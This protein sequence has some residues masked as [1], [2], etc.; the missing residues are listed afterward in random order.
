MD[1]EKL[2]IE[3]SLEGLGQFGLL[4]VSEQITVV[5]VLQML[6]EE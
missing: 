4:T 5:S 2:R 1:I 3:E 6:N